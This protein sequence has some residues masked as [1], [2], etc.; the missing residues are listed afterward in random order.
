MQAVEGFS[1]P[2]QFTNTRERDPEGSIWHRSSVYP[3]V[4]VP[5]ST[6]FQSYSAQD[7]ELNVTSV[8]RLSSTTYPGRLVG[9]T[10]MYGVGCLQ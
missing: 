3:L 4:P 5:A 1:Q 2:R 6:V 9:S 8:T 7:S 10:N